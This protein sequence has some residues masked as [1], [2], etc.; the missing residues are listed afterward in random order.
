MQCVGAVLSN[1]ACPALQVIS[2][3]ARFSGGG[4]GVIR[5]KMGFF[6]FFLLQLLSE[7]FLI[8]RRNELYEMKH[9]RWSPCKVSVIPA[10]FY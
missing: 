7:A 6:F 1:V 3:T 4:G 2:Q 5:Q 8:H 10:R 9:L